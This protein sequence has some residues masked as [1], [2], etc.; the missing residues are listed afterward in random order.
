M[1]TGTVTCMLGLII[2]EV[3]GI[4]IGLYNWKKG[5]GCPDTFMDP[6]A[7]T[8]SLDETLQLTLF[9]SVLILP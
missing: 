9:P 8:S 5:G 6:D 1:L 7:I 2:K 3:G 4:D